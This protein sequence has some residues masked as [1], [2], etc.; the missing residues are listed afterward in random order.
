MANGSAS[1][2]AAAGADMGNA[3]RV[4]ATADVDAASNSAA[5]NGAIANSSS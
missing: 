1:S 4:G 2:S 3:A 5:A